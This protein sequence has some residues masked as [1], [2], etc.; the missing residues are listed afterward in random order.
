[1]R[2]HAAANP[3]VEAARARAGEECGPLGCSRFASRALK[4]AGYDFASASSS[5]LRR[6][7]LARGG[8][9][10]PDPRAGDLF[11]H[12]GGPTGYSHV[13]VVGQD[14]IID[15]PGRSAAYRALVRRG[16][17][18]KPSVY[19]RL[20]ETPNV[21]VSSTS[22][23][24]LASRG[25]T[26]PRTPEEWAQQQIAAQE[27]K[28]PEQWAAE[29]IRQR[30][31]ETEDPRITAVQR[32]AQAKPG[33]TQQAAQAPARPAP[34]L[35]SGKTPRDF[36]GGVPIFGGMLQ[37]ELDRNAAIERQ[38]G[39]RIRGMMRGPAPAAPSMRDLLNRPTPTRAYIEGL[40]SPGAGQ[41][42]NARAATPERQREVRYQATRSAQAFN[43][44]TNDVVR[45]RTE[46]EKNLAYAEG[47]FLPSGQAAKNTAEEAW[48]QAVAD[49]KYPAP[50]QIPAH[51]KAE[52]LKKIRAA[53]PAY[54]RYVDEQQRLLDQARE[55]SLKE[56][57]RR[58][59]PL[60][61]SFDT[62]ERA[63]EFDRLDE[64][65]RQRDARIL[66]GFLARMEPEVVLKS[67]GELTP[68]Q[69]QALA[70]KAGADVVWTLQSPNI[71]RSYVF[72]AGVTAVADR[73]GAA[74]A[75][76]IFSKTPAGQ[77]VVRRLMT[78]GAI[79]G[80]IQQPATRAFVDPNATPQDLALEA[81]A[82]TAG[83]A[84][85]GGVVGA[86]GKGAR[87]V[88]GPVD[89]GAVPRPKATK[90][91]VPVVKPKAPVQAEAQAAPIPAE[92]PVAP[93]VVAK[94][95][96]AAVEPETPAA[97]LAKAKPPIQARNKAELARA[98]VKQ[99]GLPP[100]QARAGAEVFD[101]AAQTAAKQQG[102][103]VEEL[104]GRVSYAKGG[105][106]AEGALQ[107]EG[108]APIFYSQLS[109]V[110]DAKMPNRAPV[111]QLRGLLNGAGV[112]A[113]ELKWTGLDEFLGEAEKAGRP[114]TKAEVQ[115]WLRGNAVEVREVTK[116]GSDRAERALA[117]L[118]YEPVWNDGAYRLR[119]REG[120]VYS[121]H[122][123]IEAP[124]GER[125][126]IIMAWDDLNTQDATRRQM[127]TD[128][129]FGQY[130]LPGG[131][132]YRELLLT[133]PETQAAKKYRAVVEEI[134]RRADADPEIAALRARA[135]RLQDAVE[136]ASDLG[137]ARAA[138]DA[139][140]N[141]LIT[142]RNERLGDL[143]A[144]ATRLSDEDAR[145]R[146]H[147][148]HWDE[149]NVLAHVRFDER[150][151][152]DGKRVLHVAEIQSDWHQAGRKKGYKGSLPEGHRVR[153]L[154]P[155]SQ[156]YKDGFPFVVED[157]NHF[158]LAVGR[159]PE[160]AIRNIAGLAPA[161][162]FSK[163]WHEL[164]LK[165][166]LRFAAENDFERVTWDTG[167][168]NVRR[169]ED[170]FRKN[171]DE[172]Q[173]EDT[174]NKHHVRAVKDGKV[175]YEDDFDPTTG[176]GTKTFRDEIP[177][178]DEVVGK[179][180]AS[181]IL[182]SS[183]R[184]EAS[185][186]ASWSG[187]DL[188]I[189]GEGMK[190]FY[191]QILPA[192]AAKLGK[193]WGAKV[194][195]VQVGERDFV[196]A[197]KGQY[198]V[199]GADGRP[200]GGGL[201]RAEAEGL[202]LR[203]GGDVVPEQAP[204]RRFVDAH[205]LDITP[206]MRR[207]VLTEGQPLFQ[208]TKA[209]VEFTE[210][211]DALIR[212]FKGADLSSALHEHGHVFRR[213]LPEADQA[214]AAEWAGATDGNWTRPAEEKFARGFERYL[215]DGKAPTP[216][217]KQVFAK[218]REWLIGIYRRIKGSDIDV[219]VS[220]EMRDLFDRM[221]GGEGAL[222]KKVAREAKKP[223]PE[224]AASINLDK[225]NA[226]EPLKDLIRETA[227]ANDQWQAQ[228]RGTK[229]W[230]ETQKRAKE[231]IRTGV[232][233]P[234]SLKGVKR[235]TALNAE[236]VQAVA[237]L[238]VRMGDEVL[239]ARNAY[240]A[241]PT[242]ENEAAVIAAIS[243][244]GVV[245]RTL[246]GASSEA[247]RALNI[248]RLVKET[249]QG[250]VGTAERMFGEGKGEPAR[251]ARRPADKPFTGERNKDFTPARANAARDRLQKLAGIGKG[252]GEPEGPLRQEAMTPEERAA[253]KLF[254]E[255]LPD[256]RE[257]GGFYVET[258]FRDEGVPINFR[259]WSGLMQKDLGG[260]FTEPQLRT[261]WD[262]YLKPEAVQRAKSR[263]T[264]DKA[265]EKVLEALGGKDA[266]EEV[267]RK[268]A[269]FTP[270]DT[271]GLTQF[272]RSQQQWTFAD[273]MHA[274]WTANILSGVRTQGR[275]IASNAIFGITQMPVRAVAGA[276]DFVATA[277]GKVGE[278]Q[279]Y[280]SEALPAAV[281]YLRGMPAGFRKAAY[282]LQHGFGIEDAGKLEFPNVPEFRGG[283]A[284]PWN[285]VGRMLSAADALFKSMS[286]ESELHALATRQALREGLK[287]KALS[288]RV[289][290]LLLA[291]PE[292]LVEGAQKRAGYDTFTSDPD[293]VTRL[294]IGVRNTRVGGLQPVRFIMPFMNTPANILK[295]SFEFSPGG[296]AHGLA[297]LAKKDP[298]AALVTAR[299]LVG[300]AV[301]VYA[302]S[303]AAGDNLTGA[304]PQGDREKAE[305][306]RLGKQ[307][308]SVKVGGKWMDYRTLGPLAFPF[309][310]AAAFHDAYT[311][312]KKI[313]DSQRI[314]EA[315][316]A[317]GKSIVDQTFF[318][319]L[320]DLVE[321]IENPG[322]AGGNLVGNVAG[323]F[324]PLSGLARNIA[325]SQDPY[326]R[327]P[328]GIYERIIK[329]LPLVSGRVPARVGALGE[330][331]R[332]QGSEGL[333]ALSPS[334]VSPETKDPVNRELARLG[335]RPGLPGDTLT[336]R[337][338]KTKLERD[339]A[340]AYKQIPGRL[341]RQ[342]IAR[343]IGTPGYGKASDE[344]RQKALERLISHRRNQ[345]QEL[346]R[347]ALAAKR[348][349]VVLL[350]RWYDAQARNLPAL[351]EQ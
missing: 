231:L 153:E 203:V 262:R 189:G 322:R 66:K 154:D 329:D 275:N 152:A 331:L 255:N 248:H 242:P 168:E 74:A 304:A 288:E 121:Y 59:A 125:D 149:P 200:Y 278:R 87:A 185:N 244:F 63:A 346:V 160:Q 344:A 4:D 342:E 122:D 330:D 312:E 139:A 35:G 287:G 54:N 60:H 239:Q 345:A 72:D 157:R 348:D 13:G 155:E 40:T 179:D 39:Q 34:A 247:G 228:R 176:K 286:Y 315:A 246:A 14:E 24:A 307:P 257:L 140:E 90:G 133:L 134:N 44:F 91:R 227:E 205:S 237:T 269:A 164:A 108:K 198:F 128:T 305:F 245:E 1:M 328:Q 171:V 183:G 276:V 268:L 206:E 309:V 212:F 144:E 266:P 334:G 318:K 103:P 230:E 109:R 236:E 114:V 311:R 135:K 115:E 225:I 271:V 188:T 100:E 33:Y 321:A 6:Q 32:R 93:V 41:R 151:D 48:R 175:V 190:G 202:A 277:G 223:G 282:I 50:P 289:T 177:S 339:V 11:F 337:G 146:Y 79:A 46:T 47:A 340:R 101:A 254:A 211:N 219:E 197:V 308:Y 27:A 347:A 143:Q 181:Q 313:P 104:Y 132:N 274:Y 316:G 210:T 86:A 57:Q 110:V 141:A 319:G 279:I 300:S 68:L 295:R 148:P 77:A 58:A 256:L 116:G 272:L 97:P 261:L 217:L 320:S 95:K 259:E 224:Y 120:N 99:A 96:A 317:L 291:A 85:F 25:G 112:K 19:V 283:A 252:K 83:G 52:Y 267:L 281:G 124:R 182:E 350:Q 241:H 82:G 327:D 184:A 349:P 167:L 303:L 209:S 165:R 92:A 38:S 191:D 351:P 310:V 55:A 26:P 196:E 251:K 229:T 111:S 166:L 204:A 285:Q 88:M 325:Q 138:R 131:K 147:S 235:G 65:R 292:A 199:R 213:W 169:Y 118:G 81:L 37:G 238:H 69:R 102:L 226:P 332:R 23:G 265:T 343:Q 301:L 180:I 243:R 136:G 126:R 234:E 45:P 249:Y 15:A 232:I 119:D 314:S 76:K 173:W 94:A 290:D 336:I 31:N 193:K 62:P 192:A 67:M 8:Q 208:S 280:A 43:P 215:R 61:A 260:T 264:R 163:T 56:Y 158:P 150:V 302:A 98:L 156:N 49:E 299:G 123:Q 306:Y 258:Y 105:K 293:A 162:P 221:L 51:K 36:I 10:V 187:K 201:S 7:I 5:D 294:L 9:E 30:M 29:V 2:E 129:K 333:L 127:G 270:D 78:E 214:I 161:A 21:S 172:I 253:A 22:R 20:P 297:L 240:E 159:T 233:T 218:V 53:L 323:G 263:V 106:A 75:V 207:S 130:T 178:L 216:E 18:R 70:A 222:A 145:S 170:E 326:V 341:I 142:L 296:A 80:G 28:T 186:S 84:V 117:E 273:R 17:P 250:V 335:V 324:V 113:E 64:E 89:V 12:V 298:E 174:G 137:Q 107:Q 73:I 220:P 284:N 42:A 195:K 71:L 194:G 3:V 338:E 16:A